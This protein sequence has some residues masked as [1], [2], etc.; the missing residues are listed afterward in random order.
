M[1]T[2]DAKTRERISKLPEWAQGLLETLEQTALRSA[3][4]AD[5]RAEK[6]EGAR[7]KTRVF[8]GTGYEGIR[9]KI[10]EDDATLYLDLGKTRKGRPAELQLTIMEEKGRTYLRVLS[11]AEG[12]S[13]RPSS[14]NV[15]EV[16][17]E[18]NYP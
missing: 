14:S 12:L 4:A 8:T 7:I 6:D 16:G 9:V 2:I 17:V 15:V 10:A 13:V 11:S 3:R 5:A 1:V 18:D